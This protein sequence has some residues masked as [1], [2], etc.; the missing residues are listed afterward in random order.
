MLHRREINSLIPPLHRHL[1]EWPRFW[2]LSV[3][4][5][6]NY[7]I[8]D[9]HE[10][11][12]SPPEQS[13]KSECNLWH[14]G[15]MDDCYFRARAFRPLPNQIATKIEKIY[16]A[17]FKKGRKN[18][19]KYLSSIINRTEH[20]LKKLVSGTPI[21]HDAEKLFVS[22]ELGMKLESFKHGDW[23]N[24]RFYEAKNDAQYELFNYKNIAELLPD[25][26]SA[27]DSHIDNPFRAHELRNYFSKD[28]RQIKDDAEN[29]VKKIKSLI[30]RLVDKA[31]E[32]NIKHDDMVIR[33]YWII[34]DLL[35]QYG[36]KTPYNK[37]VM[38][39]GQIIDRFAQI[40]FEEC[41]CALAKVIDERF[42]IRHL[43]KQHRQDCENLARAAGV[44]HNSG[45]CYVSDS[46]FKYYLER[47]KKN[48]ETIDKMI[49]V[50]DS[51][52]QEISLAD[53]VAKSSSNPKIRRNEMMVRIR[54]TQ[55]YARAKKH[56]S[57][58]VTITCPSKY[59]AVNVNGR[60]NS[61]YNGATPKQANDYLV[62]VYAK[63]RA[64]FQSEGLAPYGMRAVEPNHDGTPHHHFL[65]FA[66]HEQIKDVVKIMQHYAL[67]EDFSESGA[68]KYRFDVKYLDLDDDAG[69]AV[70]YV[71][72]YIAKNIDGYQEDGA[73]FED[74]YKNPSNLAAAR[75]TAWR[76]CYG[77][78]AFSFIGSPSVQIWRELRKFGEG[79][80]CEIPE[81]ET[82][83]QHADNAQWDLFYDAMGGPHTKRDERP[84]QLLKTNDIKQNN[85]G[86][87]A[88]HKVKGVYYQ[89]F[90]KNEFTGDVFVKTFKELITSGET[91]T[92]YRNGESPK[93][94]VNKADVF[95]SFSSVSSE[96][97][98]GRE[99]AQPW[100]TVSNCILGSSEHPLIPQ[101]ERFFKH[102]VN[103]IPEKIAEI[104]FDRLLKGEQIAINDKHRVQLINEHDGSWAIKDV[105]PKPM[106]HI[107]DHDDW[108]EDLFEEAFLPMPAANSDKFGSASNDGY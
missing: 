1:Q 10:L 22:D 54:G 105:K 83:R 8:A 96:A 53:I 85:F 62:N 59:H 74:K 58:M 82:F 9:L 33:I 36:I 6:K 4:S 24:D 25:R 5:Q 39:N 37:E 47:S 3:S 95:P 61:T 13:S 11:K 51:T 80:D 64:A 19:N 48:K 93:T 16:S 70:A 99:P 97:A 72:K 73:I 43:R 30:Q 20:V 90:I 66:P 103:G 44:V 56:A 26:R 60:L 7:N 2:D 41:E 71:A 86:E 94:A 69:G 87:I 57:V 46:T 101:I 76:K 45:E 55:D 38:W 88:P 77:L 104:M 42:W 28:D 12:P 100:C 32:L 78:K 65:L 108:F 29:V 52:G 75:I 15:N 27:E 18:A 40:T 98:R 67:I 81:I 92:L 23:I 91:W 68:Q 14:L 89:D 106:S 63:I 79:K 35:Q 49:A 84:L 50:N 34:D 102:Y 17:K 31:E 21:I 107:D